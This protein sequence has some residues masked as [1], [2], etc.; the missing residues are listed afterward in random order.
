[1]ESLIAFSPFWLA[2]AVFAAAGYW[3]WERLFFWLDRN[4][5]VRRFLHML[6]AVILFTPAP[7]SEGSSFFAPAFLVL[8]FTALASGMDEAMYAVSWFLGGLC[9]G[10]FILAVRQFFRWMKNRSGA[11]SDS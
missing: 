6:G 7:I 3:C 11:D 1:M 9:V 8:P 10:L 5:D 2:Y 4:N